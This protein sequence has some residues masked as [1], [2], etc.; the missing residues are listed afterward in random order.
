MRIWNPSF[1]VETVLSLGVV[2]PIWIHVCT[3][4]QV[5][6]SNAETQAQCQWENA[7]ATSVNLNARMIW[8][9]SFLELRQCICRGDS[10][11]KAD[12]KNDCVCSS[13][14]RA[15]SCLWV[16]LTSALLLPLPKGPLHHEYACA[17]L[18]ASKPCPWYD[19]TFNKIA[20]KSK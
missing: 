16:R 17:C 20:K 7:L 13:S 19:S 12:K 15:Y 14:V 3:V 4:G 5:K 1:K 11:R 6:T 8:N 2:R 18:P 10:W 9:V